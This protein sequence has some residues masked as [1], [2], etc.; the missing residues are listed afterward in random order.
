V[1]NNNSNQNELDGPADLE[2][3]NANE[4]ELEIEGRGGGIVNN[5]SNVNRIVGGG[6]PGSGS[7]GGEASPL[8]RARII[9]NNGNKNVV[10]RTTGTPKATTSRGDVQ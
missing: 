7:S 8:P 6:T 4:T 5:N 9:N 10:R 1:A 2:N 3:N